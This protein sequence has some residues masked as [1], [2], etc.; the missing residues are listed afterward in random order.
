ML[1]DCVILCYNLARIYPKQFSSQFL[2]ILHAYAYFTQQDDSPSMENIRL[3]LEPNLDHPPPELDVTRPMDISFG[4]D[5]GFQI[6]DVIRAFYTC[7]SEP[8]DCLI[9]NIFIT[10]FNEAIVVLQDVVKKLTSNLTIN[11]WILWTI[12]DIFPFLP[13]PNQLALLQVSARTIEHFGTILADRGSD[14][15]WVLDDLFDPIFH[16]LWRTGLLDDALKVCEQ[17]IK[18]LDSCHHLD[19]TAAVVGEWRLNHHFVLC[20]IGRFSDAIG[21]IQHTTMALVPERYLL[22][23]HI[24][25]IRILRRAGRN[26]EAL[27]LLRRGVAAGRRKYWTNSV[28]VFNLHLDFLL[29]E[30]AAAWEYGGHQ[31]RALKHAERAVAACRKDMGPREDQKCIL[32][33][34]LITLSNCLATLGRNDEALMAA[35]EVVS[36]YTENVPHMWGDFLYTIR[37]QELGANA[38]HTLSLR[39]VTSG[40]AQ[41][42]LLNAEKATELYRELVTLAP[43]HLPTLASSLRNLGSILWDVGRRDEAVAACEE[44]VSIMRKVSSPETYFLPAV[45]EA[46]DQLASY[47]AGK[48]DVRGAA[49]AVDECAQ[50]RR[51]FTA[52]PSEPEFLFEKVVDMVELEDEWEI[53]TPGRV[54]EADDEYHN[55]SEGP[56]VEAVESDDEADKHH[57]TPEPPTSIEPLALISELSSRSSTST[58]GPATEINAPVQANPAGDSATVMGLDGSSTL[59]VQ[60]PTATDTAKSILSQPLEVDVKLRLRSTLMDVVWWVILVLGIS[61]AIAWRGVV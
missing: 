9:Q 4:G 12:I 32:I 36:I 29:S 22:L 54:S 19:D 2:W 45:A 46:L 48:G 50:V 24:V 30:S 26:Q 42:A 16:Y 1:V 7:P 5:A 38:F 3:F 41:P 51:E 14:W 34:S 15:Q 49:A 61:F 37:K 21:M 57:D 25:Q 55:A 31:E 28:E 13:T 53:P 17:V 44:A 18:F 40:K 23:P 10:H 58:P 43:R 20:D 11:E 59:A 35:K 56:S 52:L 60:N 47:L 27:Q 33:H 8:G 39:L 6:E